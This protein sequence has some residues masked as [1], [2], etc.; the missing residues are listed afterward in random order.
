MLTELT[1]EGVILRAGHTT[2]RNASGSP[3][4]VVPN[5]VFQKLLFNTD[6]EAYEDTHDAA[7]LP[8]SSIKIPA[9]ADH[10]Q[11][12]AHAAIAWPSD[13]SGVAGQWRI[14]LWRDGAPT[15]QDLFYHTSYYFPIATASGGTYLSALAQTPLIPVVNNQ[16]EWTL[17]TKQITGADQSY[18]SG[19]DMWMSVYYAKLAK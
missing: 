10:V 14:H 1:G 18:L 6:G 17:V 3:N 4:Q 19:L 13:V 12:T 16:E 7:N 8:N 11:V 9:W 2:I 5:N 15:T